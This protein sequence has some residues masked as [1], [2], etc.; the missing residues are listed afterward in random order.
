[1]ASM[2]RTSGYLENLKYEH[3]L[4][5]VRDGRNR[6]W[7][8]FAN[9]TAVAPAASAL[10]KQ[11]PKFSGPQYNLS[12]SK[13]SLLTLSCYLRATFKSFLISVPHGSPVLPWWRSLAYLGSCRR[14]DSSHIGFQSQQEIHRKHFVRLWNIQ[15][16]WSLIIPL[17]SIFSN[18]MYA[19]I[20]NSS[21]GETFGK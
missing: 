16:S 14:L 6:C 9:A 1:M 21:H 3:Q 17:R 2:A 8:I 15:I 19:N 7:I 4:R 20:N 11:A 13:F 12:E 5:F 18:R 10:R